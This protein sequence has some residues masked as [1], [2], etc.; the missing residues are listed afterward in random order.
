MVEEQFIVILLA[1]V[2]KDMAVGLVNPKALQFN[3]CNAHSI[4]SAQ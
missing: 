2:Y 4:R 3:G 1:L